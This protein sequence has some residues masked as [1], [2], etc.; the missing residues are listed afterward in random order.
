MDEEAAP[1]AR[2]RPRDPAALARTVAGG[3]GAGRARRAAALSRVT[4]P[5]GCGGKMRLRL[6]ALAAAILLGLVPGKRGARGSCTG[7]RG[8]R[9]RGGLGC[10]GSWRRTP[11]PR[12]WRRNDVHSSL[13]GS[14]VLLA[15]RGGDPL[16]GQLL[17][18]SEPQA[19]E[20]RVKPT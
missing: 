2:R 17:V 8:W 13:L 14:L 12:S 3:R 20:L 1:P 11:T 19:A 10:V 5:D 15:T 7:G 9:G 16:L 4:A 18:P 6:L